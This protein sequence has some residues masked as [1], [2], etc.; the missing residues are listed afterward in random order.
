MLMGVARGMQAM[1]EASPPILH[2]DLKPSNV[3]IDAGN[4]ARVADMGLARQWT[5]E[6]RP[7]PGLMS[8]SLPDSKTLLGV[9]GN[10]SRTHSDVHS[11]ARYS[12]VGKLHR[13]S[14]WRLLVRTD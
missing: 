8:K 14:G 10:C 1:E 3:F 12:T 11:T 4:Q 13:I 2:R 6:V 9:A 5:I 7:A